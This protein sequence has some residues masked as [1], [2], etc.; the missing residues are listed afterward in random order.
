MRCL[1]IVVPENQLGWFVAV[2]NTLK[3]PAEQRP[4]LPKVS[5]VSQVCDI[6]HVKSG[7]GLLVT[8][9]SPVNLHTPLFLGR[10]AHDRE[11]GHFS[12]ASS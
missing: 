8:S 6:A 4:Y 11:L 12:S 7:C 5:G 3:S 2:A 10:S 1:I 9:P